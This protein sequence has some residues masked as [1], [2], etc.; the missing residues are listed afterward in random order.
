M[1]ALDTV[2]YLGQDSQSP[3]IYTTLIPEK[4]IKQDY[5]D[6]LVEFKA[7]LLED[8]SQHDINKDN[9]KQRLIQLVDQYFKSKSIDLNNGK[10]FLAR[11]ND[12]HLIYN[13][14][15]TAYSDFL[16]GETHL[17]FFENNDCLCVTSSVD[18][19]SPLDWSPKENPYSKINA[20]L[21]VNSFEQRYPGNKINRKIKQDQKIVHIAP[22][23]YFPKFVN[24]TTLIAPHLQ[25]TNLEDYCA[26]HEAYH[27]VV[28]ERKG[29]KPNQR[30]IVLKQKLRD[31]F[32]HEL[33]VIRDIRTDEFER[34]NI[35]EF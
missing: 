4:S 12:K 24:W 1:K 25:R 27:Q 29:D 32:E 31:S 22:L 33:S 7:D 26:L 11:S 19:S 15:K 30:E 28:R 3:I 8:P 20:Y 2:G 34:M 14:N 35:D 9:L 23:D 10:I 13:S 17:H 6:L 5:V 16:Q 18:F 21:L